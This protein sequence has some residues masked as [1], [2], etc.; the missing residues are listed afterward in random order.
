MDIDYNRQRSPSPV[1][2]GS[3]VEAGDGAGLGHGGSIPFWEWAD[4][5]FLAAPQ[6]RGAVVRVLGE[7]VCAYI[8]CLR[9]LHLLSRQWLLLA[10]PPFR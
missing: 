6:G 3:E 8:A 5:F 1:A 10:S 7:A 4:T 2:G 9:Y